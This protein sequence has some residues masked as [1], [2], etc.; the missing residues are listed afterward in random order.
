MVA[1]RDVQERMQDGRLRRIA[2]RPVG[3]DQRT[4]DPGHIDLSLQY[5]GFSVTRKLVDRLHVR[6]NAWPR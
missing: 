5:D 4:L 3:L 2:F 1:L 6:N